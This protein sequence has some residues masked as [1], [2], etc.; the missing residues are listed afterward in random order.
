MVRD[1]CL[2]ACSPRCAVRHRGCADA[3]DTHSHVCC[4][5]RGVSSS[6]IV[7]DSTCYCVVE[8]LRC[9]HACRHTFRMKFLRVVVFTPPL[10]SSFWPSACVLTGLWALD[11]CAEMSQEPYLHRRYLE[12]VLLASLARA[13][14]SLRPLRQVRNSFCSPRTMKRSQMASGQPKGLWKERSNH[15]GTVDGPHCARNHHLDIFSVTLL[16]SMLHFEHFML[17]R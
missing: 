11:A 1:G 12:R 4:A 8:K 7:S 17:F 15:W 5:W 9:S 3:H 6:R 16:P 10:L 2:R 14:F 13:I